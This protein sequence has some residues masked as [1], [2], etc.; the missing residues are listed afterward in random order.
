MSSQNTARAGRSVLRTCRSCPTTFGGEARRVNQA[1]S[2][3]RRD[4]HPNTCTTGPSFLILV[5][6][7]ALAVV[8]TAATVAAAIVW[9]P[10]AA[11]SVACTGLLVVAGLCLRQV[12]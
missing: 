7:L 4:E 3:H 8:V 12:R 11:L 5:G 10:A 1:L 2:E 9:S 6:A